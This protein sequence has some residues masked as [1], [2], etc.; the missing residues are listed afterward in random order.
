MSMTPEERK[1]FHKTLRRNHNNLARKQ[2]LEYRAAKKSG[3]LPLES[4]KFPPPPP[5]WKGPKS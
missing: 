3:A 4:L 1:D 5:P 2:E